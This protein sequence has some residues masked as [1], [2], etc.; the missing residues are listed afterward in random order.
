[1]YLKNLRKSPSHTVGL[2]LLQIAY[3][4]QNLSLVAI[5]HGGL[6]TQLCPMFLRKIF[7]RSPSHTVGLEQQAAT[8]T[9]PHGGWKLSYVF[10]GMSPSHTVGLEPQTTT[11]TKIRH[12][13]HFVKG[14]PFSN[15]V[16]FPKSEIMQ[17]LVCCYQI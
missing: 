16:N 9:I 8:K 5:P 7:I 14:A 10:E 13:N 11:L 1:M 12:I 4:N 15:E 6:G 3:N 17:S 2:E